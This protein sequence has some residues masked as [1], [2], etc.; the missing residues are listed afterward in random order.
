MRVTGA[1]RVLSRYDIGRSVCLHRVSIEKNNRTGETRQPDGEGTNAQSDIVT[2]SPCV[3]A[4]RIVGLERDGDQLHDVGAGVGAEP[5]PAFSETA[6]CRCPASGRGKGSEAETMADRRQRARFHLPLHVPV[7][8]GA[9]AAIL[10]S[11]PI[12]IRATSR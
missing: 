6:T 9:P 5:H 7:P 4:G 12:C 2:R 10:G 8:V 3:L 1:A 11:A